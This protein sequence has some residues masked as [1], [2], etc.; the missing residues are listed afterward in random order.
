[1]THLSSWLV[2]GHLLTVSECDLSSMCVKKESLVYLPILKEHLSY[3]LQNYYMMKFFQCKLI[4]WIEIPT[5]NCL[6]PDSKPYNYSISD[7][8]I[9]RSS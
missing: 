6:S 7:F 3:Q 8:A 5:L 2:D 4:Y 1:M 9:P